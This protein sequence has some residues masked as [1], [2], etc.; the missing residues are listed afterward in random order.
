MEKEIFINREISWLAFNERVLQ[1]ANDLSVP[2]IDRLKFLGIFSNNLDEFFRVRVASIKRTVGIKSSRKDVYENPKLL[3]EEMHQKVIEQQRVFEKTYADILKELKKKGVVLTNELE[4][5]LPQ[6]KFSQDYF[7]EIVRPSLVPLMLSQVKTFPYL[8][9]K[10]IYF[11]I[12]LSSSQNSKKEFALLEIPTDILNRFIEIPSNSS[13]QFIILLDDLIRHNLLSLFS[14]FNYDKAEAYTIKLTRDAELDLDNDVTQSFIDKLYK[15]VK[16]RQKGSAVRLVYDKEMP[17]DLFNYLLNRMKIKKSDNII[18][19]GR[20]HNFKDFMKF[21]TFNNKELNYPRYKEVYHPALSQNKL[22]FDVLQKQDILIQYPYQT[23]SHYIDFLREAA[24]DPNVKSIKMTLYR[25]A[26]K[27]R[28]INALISAARNGKKVTV[29]LELQARFDEEAN[30]KWGKV[31]EEEGIKV[32]YGIPGLKI[33]AKL[34]LIERVEGIKKLLFANIS[35]GNYNEDTAHTYSDHALF[36]SSPEL[37]SDVL[38][39][40]DY[41]QNPSRKPV[42]KNLVL[43]P[44]DTRDHFIKLINNEIRLAKKGKQT[45]ITLKMN[46]LVDESV[47]TKLYAASKAGVKCKLIIRGICRL[48]AGVKGLSENIEAISII[49]RFLE[50]SRLYRFENGGKPIFYISS[51]D[52]MP[53]NLDV[54]I[55]VSCK[56]NNPII[57]VQLQDYL[58]TQWKANV[59]ARILDASLVNTYRKTSN[60]AFRS[61]MKIGEMIS[62]YKN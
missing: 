17:I 57:K 41:I 26:K 5:S 10:S 48:K 31:L 40:F 22:F 8:K 28:V 29:V 56:V 52:F 18:S 4:L 59:K 42:L 2:L 54:R 24:I 21:P 32:I 62:K 37:T 20:Y 61:Q 13:K 43:S 38:K 6:K 36:T 34:C 11:A 30:I 19:G 51:C 60:P 12:K 44:Y 35:T 14:T 45:G 25:A 46:S 55:E 3:L 15:S 7:K 49:D 39:V 23:F 9:D 33:H 50:H 58:D 53:R 1:E 27:S 16:N 47:I